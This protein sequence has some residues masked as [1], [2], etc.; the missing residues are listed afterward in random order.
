MNG[1]M[2]RYRTVLLTKR[3]ELERAL[4]SRDDIAI[5][6]A[7]DGLDAI[8][9]AQQRD[10]AICEVERATHELRA[11]K[12]ALDRIADGTFG[13]CL[14]CEERI[15]ERRL[16]AVP[17]AAHCVSCQENIERESM[18]PGGAPEELARDAFFRVELDSH[19]K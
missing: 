11:I 19:A 16:N 1:T 17:W 7:P 6:R 5:E 8:H 14:R 13:V 18:D 2:E 12:G 15:S 3:A 10:L 9:L 4:Q